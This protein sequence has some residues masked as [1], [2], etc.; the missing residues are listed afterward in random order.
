M[1][2][3]LKGVLEA[4]TAKI[5]EKLDLVIQNQ[6]IRSVVRPQQGVQP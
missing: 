2:A 4:E 1:V 5:N 3:E 6:Q